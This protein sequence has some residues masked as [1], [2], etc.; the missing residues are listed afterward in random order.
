MD[1]LMEM[2]LTWTHIIIGLSFFFMVVFTFSVFLRA[3][4]EYADRKEMK[5][6]MDKIRDAMKFT[7]QDMEVKR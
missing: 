3:Y 6:E 5:S 4:N 7:K 1:F 2:V